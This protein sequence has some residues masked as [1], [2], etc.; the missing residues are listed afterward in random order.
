MSRNNYILVLLILYLHGNIFAQFDNQFVSHLSKHELQREHLTYLQTFKESDSI[1]FHLAKYY[2]QY[3]DD[4]LFFNY[5]QKST[6]HFQS[7]TNALNL[8][9]IYFVN[10]PK[11]KLWF[12]TCL[13]QSLVVPNISKQLMNVQNSI[14]HPKEFNFQLLPEKLQVDFQKY[15]KISAKKP[16]VAMSLSALVPGLGKLYIGSKKSFTVTLLSMTVLGL[17][18]YESYRSKGISHP[19]TLI[20]LGF[21]TTYYA[22][23]LFG[24][25]RETKL[26]RKELKTQYLINASDYYRYKYR[27]SLY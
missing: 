14:D 25:Y 11:S 16:I 7:D 6:T 5:F 21:F 8:A 15:Q 26:K 9:S 1:S 3:P 2:L 27:P 13:N 23:N 18:S 12:D 20:N 19:L 22:V 24:S 10:S 4:S 17:Q